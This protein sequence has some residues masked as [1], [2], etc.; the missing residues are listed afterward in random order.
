MTGR[1]PELAVIDLVF[2]Y[3]DAQATLPKPFTPAQL[4]HVLEDCVPRWTAP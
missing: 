2:R 1:A 3:P 4:I